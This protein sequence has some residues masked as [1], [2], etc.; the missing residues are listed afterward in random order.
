MRSRT[1]GIFHFEPFAHA[2]GRLGTGKKIMKG[3]L[4]RSNKTMTWGEILTNREVDYCGGLVEELADVPWALPLVRK[5]KL[6]GYHYSS[7]PLLF[8]LRFA[9]ELHRRGLQAKYEAQQGNA[10]G[11]VDFEFSR[12]GLTW[13]VEL[14]SI[15]T[16]Q[17]VKDAT[18]HSGIF[19][20]TAL[21]SDASDARQ[22]EEGEILIAQ[23]KIVGKVLAGDEVMK[24]P[25]PAMNRYHVVIADMRGFGL[26]GGDVL[27]YREIAFGPRAF[28]QADVHFRHFWK[29]KD[30]SFQPIRGIFEKE[31]QFLRGASAFQQRIH[32]LGFSFDEDYVPGSVVSHSYY[33]GNPHLEGGTDANVFDQYPM[34]PT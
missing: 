29:S 26:T 21:S 13:A 24:F 33:V 7:K 4:L 12:D 8:E 17:A 9:S 32:L 2:F 25:L 11:S 28:T 14:V 5:V 34:R 20:Q 19:F 15:M 6:A 30:G 1:G 22:S 31:N 18:V 3:A 27:D 23:Q 16:S 10:P